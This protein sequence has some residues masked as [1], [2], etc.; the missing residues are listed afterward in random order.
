MSVCSV[1]CAIELGGKQKI[2][3][4]TLEKFAQKMP[5]S[6]KFESIILNTNVAFGLSLNCFKEELIKEYKIQS[7]FFKRCSYRIAACNESF[8]RFSHFYLFLNSPFEVI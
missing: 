1:Q 5:G 2:T 8:S 3:T 7:F 6:A 4:T